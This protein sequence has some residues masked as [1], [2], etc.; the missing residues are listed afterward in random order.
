MLLNS[1]FYEKLMTTTLIDN[2]DKD[3]EKAGMHFVLKSRT[4]KGI[5]LLYDYSSKI[6]Y[7][8]L[9]K[10][11]KKYPEISAVS[12]SGFFPVKRLNEEWGFNTS[13]IP[14]DSDLA[15]EYFGMEVF[16]FEPQ[17]KDSLSDESQIF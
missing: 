5:Y 15:F 6:D 3:I 8:E 14:K 12:T 9:L 11:T 10:L 2:L 17:A 13:K 7:D 1:F 4:E 16:S